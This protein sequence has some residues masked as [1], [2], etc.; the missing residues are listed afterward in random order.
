[1]IEF[2]GRSN[3]AGIF[4]VIVVYFGGTRRSCIMI[5]VSSNHASWSLFQKEL[6]NFCFGAK[7]VSMAKVSF[8][9]GGGS[10]QFASGGRS[11]KIMSVYDN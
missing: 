6:R 8:N 11:G 10:G 9:S 7:S 4:V 2:C 5:L 3:K 1:M